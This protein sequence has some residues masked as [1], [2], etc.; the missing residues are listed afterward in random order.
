MLS[1]PEP[2]TVRFADHDGRT[3]QPTEPCVID[4]RIQDVPGQ[5]DS[6]RD[7]LGSAV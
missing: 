1:S 7:K 3:L 4:S 5:F 2:A 6:A